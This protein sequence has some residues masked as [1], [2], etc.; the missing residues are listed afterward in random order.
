MRG[1]NTEIKHKGTTL[2]VQTQD[3][4]REA[5]YVESLVYVTGKVLTSRKTFYTAF[6]NNPTLGDKIQH[7]TNTQHQ[8]VLDEITEGQYDH[9][10]I[11]D[12]NQESS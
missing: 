12:D 2:H 7:I 6:L 5:Q 8:K 3:K 1:F 10:L 4:G 9:F 11:P